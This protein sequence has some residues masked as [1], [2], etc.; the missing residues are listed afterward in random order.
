MTYADVAH[1]HYEP[2]YNLEPAATNTHRPIY[3]IPPTRYDQVVAASSLSERYNYD[4]PAQFSPYGAASEQK[5]TYT[6]PQRDYYQSQQDYLGAASAL[7]PNYATSQYSGRPTYAG[8]QHTGSATYSK[9]T[10]SK[11][12]GVNTLKPTYAGYQPISASSENRRPTYAGYE[13]SPAASEI[14]YQYNVAAPSYQS[15][16]YSPSYNSQ[17]TSYQAA[18]APTYSQSATVQRNT[19]TQAPTTDQKRNGQYNP[20]SSTKSGQ[21]VQK[22]QNRA[23]QYQQQASVQR[24]YYS[25]APSAQTY[26][27]QPAATRVDSTIVNEDGYHYEKPTIPFDPA[28]LRTPETPSPLY[29]DTPL[30]ALPVRRPTNPPPQ[31][32]EPDYYAPVPTPAPVRFNPAPVVTKP[33]FN[34]A[35]APVQFNPAPVVTKT[36]FNPAPAPVR[37]NPPPVVATITKPTLNPTP[38]PVRFNPAP[39]VTKPAFNPAPSPVRFNPAPVFAKPAFDP[40]PAPVRTTVITPDPFVQFHP[41]PVREPVTPPPVKTT[42]LQRIE[43]IDNIINTPTTPTPPIVRITPRTTPRPRPT[44]HAIVNTTPFIVTFPP[45]KVSD[46]V[47]LAYSASTISP[48]ISPDVYSPP[49]DVSATVSSIRVSDRVIDNNQPEVASPAPF[50]ATKPVNPIRRP[51]RELETSASEDQFQYLPPESPTFG[52][53]RD[54]GYHYQ[55]PSI[56]FF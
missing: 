48:H 26:N 40:A 9:P 43:E 15:N 12:Q 5:S 23:G 49:P 20:Q 45:P 16:S 1:L 18:T 4:P 29:E 33:T 14:G 2:Q 39:V 38:A 31:Y 37:F 6:T 42:S 47:L 55:L 46:V 36:T 8:Y 28:P 34:P 32:R 11:P 10:Y 22:S 52:E 44:Q 35:P 27:Y 7:Q 25:Q 30:P 21:Y 24:N 13:P 51:D 41:E 54:D 50:I 19:Y 56:P 53:L 3:T 17:R